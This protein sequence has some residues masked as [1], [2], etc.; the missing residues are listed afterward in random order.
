MY[1]YGDW[2]YEE[3]SP[4]WCNGSDYGSYIK[5]VIIEEG[6]TGIGVYNFY[7]SSVSSV[8]LPES[9]EKIDM[10]AFH[11]CANL[12][13]ITIPKNVTE[14]GDRAFGQYGNSGLGIADGFVVYG[15]E[16]SA[17]EKYV[18]DVN[19]IKN[20]T[21]KLK[22]VAVKDNTENTVTSSDSSGSNSTSSS[23]KS[24]PA[25][26]DSIPKVFAATAIAGLGAVLFRKRNRKK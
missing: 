6:I 8:V 2:A 18:N 3:Q 17:A 15:Y 26:G 1:N 9:L 23:G 7:G 14:I 4:P 25:T 13:E 12:K 20:A 22:F 5:T 24:A 11:D 19:N 16:G 10:L 21:G